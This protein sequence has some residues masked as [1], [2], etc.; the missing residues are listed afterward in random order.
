MTMV[1][2]SAAS[3]GNRTGTGRNVIAIASG[4]GGVGKTWFAITLTQALG[5]LGGK[6][7]LFDGDIGLA[8]VDVQLGLPA[9]QDLA[10]VAAGRAT[11]A[12]AVQAFPAGG[13]DLVAGIS[14][15]GALADLDDARQQTLSLAMWRLAQ[16]YRHVVLDLGAG[17]DGLVRRLIPP[18]ATVLVLAT[19]EPT[20][21]TDAYA[22]IKLTLADRA[23]ADLRIVVNMA[24]G[25]REGERTYGALLRAC[26]GFL[27]A[28]PPLAGI[29]RHDAKVRDA[30]RHQTALLI[31]HPNSE[32]AADVLAIAETLQR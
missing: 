25:K 31:R 1:E 16:G 29:V 20:S 18:R 9:R 3:V 30:I 14:G 28:S 26:Q 32:A 5:Q 19:D 27:K 11:L 17:V 12:D 4:K 8:N 7:L 2:P 22:F 24:R 15:S 23:N 6:C 13:F 21:L 10:A